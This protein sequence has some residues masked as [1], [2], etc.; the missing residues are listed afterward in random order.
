MHSSNTAWGVHRTFCTKE[1]AA[2]A[3]DS[4]AKQHKSGESDVLFNSES[5]EAGETAAA[6]VKAGKTK[7]TGQ[8]LCKK[9]VS[10]HESW[11]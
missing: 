4:A 3:Y 2:A 9:E 8:A 11:C 6:D 5:A 1:E 7:A 10:R